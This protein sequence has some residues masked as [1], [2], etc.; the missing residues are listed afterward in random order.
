MAEKLHVAI[1]GFGLFAETSLLPAFKACAL[2]ELVAITKRSGVDV[3]QKA[4]L[5]GIPKACAS[6]DQGALLRDPG[7]DAVFV[8]TPNF[9]HE[10]DVIAALEAGKHVLVE[11]PMAMNVPSCQAMIDAATSSKRQL[12]VAHCLRFNTSVL[13][14]KDLIESGRIGRP[15]SLTCDF[16]S[17]GRE[18]KR[19]WKYEKS[20]AGGGAS[21]DLG[22][23]II[24][25]IRFL[26]R[27]PV[28]RVEA[29][30]RPDPLPRDEVDT[31]SSFLITFGNGIVGRATASYDGPRHTFLEAYGTRGYA[32]AFDFQPSNG[33][34]R[35]ESEIEG[36][37]EQYTVHNGDYYAKEID[38]FAAAVLDGH[39]VPV[40][41]EE[42][43]EN[44]RI[45]DLVNHA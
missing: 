23:H 2:A 20:M 22:V 15:V 45:I 21:F 33:V 18:S 6:R 24:D 17:Q 13:R 39:P 43:L 40:P 5:H 27:A 38:A 30:F 32:R 12:M 4:R 1:L 31:L 8:A 28:T 37:F 34:V 9:L 16:M 14:V 36:V 7:I 35:F 29:T 41:G 26:A 10:H 44:Q 3:Q 25:T 19:K 42:G 11:K